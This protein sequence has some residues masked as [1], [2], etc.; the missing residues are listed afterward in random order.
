MSRLTKLMRSL[1]AD[2]TDVVTATNSPT[3]GDN[4][5]QLATSEFLQ[6]ALRS[7]TTITTGT[8]ALTY[9]DHGFILVDASG[10]TVTINLPPAT[11]RCRFEFRRIDTTSNA[12]T[13]NR[14]GSDTIEASGTSVS[15]VGNFAERELF[16][17]GASKWYSPLVYGQGNF[18]PTARG[19]GTTGTFTYTAQSGQ[20]Q[21]IGNRVFFNL[22]IG[23]SASSGTGGLRIKIDSIPYL[24]GAAQQAPVVIRGDGLEVGT[25]KTVQGYV[26]A[27]NNEIVLEAKPE[28]GGS[29]DVTVDTV[30]GQ[31]MISGHYMTSL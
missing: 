15:L 5:K 1:L 13:I 16:S 8:T 3:K 17:D 10:G 11:V 25:G 9:G 6:T 31:L 23:W 4:T 18:T 22:N 7:V 2:G 12:V 21:R 29:T 24:P 26:T 14:A 30:V 20:W 28:S 19:T 27:L